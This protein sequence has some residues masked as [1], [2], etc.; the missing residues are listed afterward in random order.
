MIGSIAELKCAAQTEN[1]KQLR[2]TALPSKMVKSRVYA[3]IMSKTV[4]GVQQRMKV[5]MISAEVFATLISFCF[6]EF[7]SI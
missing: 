3:I 6:I 7:S 4:M 1:M 5:P 2:D